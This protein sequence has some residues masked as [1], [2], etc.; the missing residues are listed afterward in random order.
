ML[1]CPKMCPMLNQ[2]G[3]CRDTMRTPEH[4]RVCPHQAIDRVVRKPQAA[5]SEMC[6]N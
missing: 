1:M 4:S 6:P 5:Q 3:Y 2:Y